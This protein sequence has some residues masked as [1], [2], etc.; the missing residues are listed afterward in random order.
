MGFNSGFKGLK[1]P[2]LIPPVIFRMGK[3]GCQ[4][5]KQTLIGLVSRY[6]IGSCPGE[7]IYAT[8]LRLRHWTQAL[9]ILPRNDEIR[10]EIWTEIT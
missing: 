10:K 1:T 9:S 5:T 6:V 7:L 4:K 8:A 2:L 3:T